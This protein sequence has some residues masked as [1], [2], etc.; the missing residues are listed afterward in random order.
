METITE[1]L[2]A[3]IQDAVDNGGWS[4]LAIAQDAG[5]AQPHLRSWLLGQSDLRL[6]T[7]DKLAEWCRCRLT[8]PRAP[9]R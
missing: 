9:K 5:V 8:K 1:T 3:A 7:A 2:R 4:V 6:A